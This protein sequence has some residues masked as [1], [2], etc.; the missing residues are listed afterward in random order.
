MKMQVSQQKIP[1][2]KDWH[3]QEA[4]D[5]PSG[6]EGLGPGL[7]G[8]LALEGEETSAHFLELLLPEPAHPNAPLLLKV[9]T[10]SLI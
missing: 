8:G 3:L 7:L 9:S 4:F 6:E 5:H 10:A 2:K 1:N